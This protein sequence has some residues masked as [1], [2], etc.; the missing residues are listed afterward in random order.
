MVRNLFL[1]LLFANLLLLSWIFWVDPEPPVPVRAAGPNQLAL[2]GLARPAAAERP[3]PDDASPRCYFLGPVPDL[4]AAQ[5]LSASLAERGIKVEPVSRAGRVWVGHW[6]Q[7]QGFADR[8]VAEAARQRLLGAGLPD[9]YVMQDGPINIISLGVFRERS[10]AERVIEAARTAGFEAVLRERVRATAEYWLLFDQA[11]SQQA[12]L[13]ELA[14]GL[15]RI[16]RAEAGPC[17][18]VAYS[19]SGSVAPE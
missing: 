11:E 5:Q 14:P 10:R 19:A 12:A 3:A 7:I 18:P 4:S 6:V 2:F 9:A 8:E 17:P 16:L 1:I 13:G 15:D